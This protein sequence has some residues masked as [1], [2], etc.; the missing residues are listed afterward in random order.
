[1]IP[2]K[3]SGL[4]REQYRFILNSR[5]RQNWAHGPVRCGKNFAINI[6]FVEALRTAPRGF[7]YTDVAFTG[8]SKKAIYRVFLKDLFEWIGRGNYTYD[9][10]TGSGRIFDREFY[11]F[12]HCDSDSHEAI[13][14]ST[15]GLAYMTEGVYAHQDFHKQLM[16]RLSIEDLEDPSVFAMLFGDTNPAGPQH[17][18]WT[19]VINN[20]ELLKAGDIASFP[21]TFD[22][23]R[24]ISAGYRDSLKRQYKPGSLWF[25]RMIQ[26]LWVMAEGIIFANFQMG[27]NT[28]PLQKMP[29]KGFERTVIAC[30][31]GTQNPFAAL[32]VG[33]KDGRFYVLDEYYHNGRANG[34]KTNLQYADE[35]HEWIGG[36]SVDALYL[37]PSASGMRIE[38]KNHAKFQDAAIPIKLAE[39][40]VEDGIQTVDS[41]LFQGNLILAET[42]SHT[43]K[44]MGSYA[45]CPSAQ[46]RGEDKPLKKDDHCMDALR[47]ALHTEITRQALGDDDEAWDAIDDEL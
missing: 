7:E 1:M 46:K 42:C 26:G 39:N 11:S 37:D 40:A 9:K 36:R 2:K 30:D 5:A 18:L 23:N 19:D 15:F 28:R 6:R 31:Y 38:L 25:K 22:S 13:S 20:P 34:Q 32:L 29:T 27:K 24:S 21:F 35:L 3:L 8:S 45:W 16:A 17:W 44:E 41:A 10:S 14:G 47:Y 4:S 43:L 33:I 12:T